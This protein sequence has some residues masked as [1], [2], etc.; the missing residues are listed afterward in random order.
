MNLK[1]YKIIGNP[2]VTTVFLILTLSACSSVRTG[3][4]PESTNNIIDATPERTQYLDVT[5][6]GPTEDLDDSEVDQVEIPPESEEPPEDYLVYAI[7]MYQNEPKTQVSYYDPATNIT[8]PILQGWDIDVR[9]FSI[10]QN[11]QLAFSALNNGKY[12]IYILDYPFTSNEPVNITHDLNR[13]DFVV[14]WSRDGKLLAYRAT[15]EEGGTISIL[16]GNTTLDIYNFEDRISEFTW[17]FDG[18]L[19]FTDY[20]YKDPSHE[21]E[22]NEVL[23]WDGNSTTSVRLNPKGVD[24]FPAWSEDGEL[25]FLSEWDDDYDIF[26]WDGQSKINGNPDSKTFINVAPELTSYVSNPVWTRK[27][28]IAFSAE[29]PKDFNTEIYEWDGSEVKNISRE[30]F[31]HDSGQSWSS[32]GYWAFTTF[33]SSKQQL[34]VRD[35]ANRTL[36]ITKGQYS[37]AWGESGNLIFCVPRRWTLSIWNRAEVIEIAHGDIIRAQWRNGATIFCSSG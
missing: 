16:D 27:G 14:S 10:S 19:A 7:Y 23:V 28:S 2:I 32:D 21:E 35:D 36:L 26:V 34:Y 5:E 18:R 12:D 6:P 24:R 8:R 3:N 4:L 29:G 30:I 22:S 20:S 1:P 25:A 37:P 9:S 31:F 11:N 33:L 15:E 13:D 17:S